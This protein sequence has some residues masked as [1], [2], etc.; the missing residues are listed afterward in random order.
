M[1]IKKVKLCFSE[2]RSAKQEILFMIVHFQP[3][4]VYSIISQYDFCRLNILPA[5]NLMLL[6]PVEILIEWLA[7]HRLGQ[8][9]FDD[10]N[11]FYDHG[12]HRLDLYDPLLTKPAIFQLAVLFHDLDLC[13]HHEFVTMMMDYH[14]FFLDFITTEKQCTIKSVT[15]I[16]FKN[17]FR[18]TRMLRHTNVRNKRR[19]RSSINP[20]KIDK[21]FF[22]FLSAKGHYDWHLFE[23]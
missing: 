5:D 13:P 11:I 12:H 8:F 19:N 2:L 17:T 3:Q 4:T 9:L 16:S 18:Y 7:F 15:T 20:K 23:L 14:Q 10:C 22:S 21:N 6:L 1:S